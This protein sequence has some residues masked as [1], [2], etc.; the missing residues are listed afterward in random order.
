MASFAANRRAGLS[1]RITGAAIGAAQGQGITGQVLTTMA[2][3]E[4]AGFVRRRAAK[5]SAYVLEKVARLTGIETASRLAQRRAARACEEV[6]AAATAP[7]PRKLRGK[8]AIPATGRVSAMVGPENEDV[9]TKGRQRAA[10]TIRDIS[11]AVNTPGKIVAMKHEVLT[12]LEEVAPQTAG[13]IADRMELAL[14]FLHEKAPKN[15]KTKGNRFTPSVAQG[16]IPSPGQVRKYNRYIRAIDDPIGTI[17]SAA[18]G[19]HDSE[20]I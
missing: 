4:G 18:Y 14:H 12:A 6:A 1:D 2:A 11:D 16:W 19:H 13:H 5:A 9:T 10:I 3:Q 7:K 17:H 15:P 20:S 8:L